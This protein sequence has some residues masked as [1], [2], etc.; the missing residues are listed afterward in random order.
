MGFLKHQRKQIQAIQR[1]F[2]YG[3]EEKEGKTSGTG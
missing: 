2:G 1:G 3:D